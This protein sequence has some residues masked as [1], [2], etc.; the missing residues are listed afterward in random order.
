MKVKETHTDITE[1]KRGFNKWRSKKRHDREQVPEA[2]WQAAAGLCKT[3]RMTTVC[4][5]LG[6]ERKKLRKRVASSVSSSA[7]GGLVRSRNDFVTVALPPAVGGEPCSGEVAA[8]WIRPID[9]ARLRISIRRDEVASV[10]RLFL[11]GDQ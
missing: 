4:R 9:G 5:E 11:G 7:Q 10:M 1:I 6:L 2:L 3:H 8:E